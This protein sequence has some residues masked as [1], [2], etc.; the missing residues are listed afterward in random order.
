MVS[1]FVICLIVHVLWQVCVCV[2]TINTEAGKVEVEKVSAD[3]LE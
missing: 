3:I 2:D 1:E